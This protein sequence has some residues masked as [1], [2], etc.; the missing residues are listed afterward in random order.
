[1]IQRHPDLFAGSDSSSVN[2]DVPSEPSEVLL[3]DGNGGAEKMF[4]DDGGGRDNI[5]LFSAILSSIS[6]NCKLVSLMFLRSS[7]HISLFCKFLS[8]QSDS[9]L[10]VFHR[11]NL[12][13]Y[14]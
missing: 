1:M 2:G 5:F 13:L 12:F 11:S 9:F 8:G 10:N 4:L 14:F 7:Y 6:V 3:L